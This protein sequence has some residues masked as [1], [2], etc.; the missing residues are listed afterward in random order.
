MPDANRELK[1]TLKV[2]G[3]TSGGPPSTRIKGVIYDGAYPDLTD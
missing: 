1:F 2:K 3:D